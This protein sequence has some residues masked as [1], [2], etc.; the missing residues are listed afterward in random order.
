MMLVVLLGLFALG[1]GS[2]EADF[3]L[4]VRD[5]GEHYDRAELKARY[6][7]FKSNKAMVSAHNSQPD[8][9][10]TMVVNKFSA[11]TVSERSKYTGL[12]NE[13]NV[14]QTGT[15]QAPRG[16][17]VSPASH[18]NTA[19]GYVTRLKD[20]RSCG[21]CWAFA[22]SAAFEG[23]YA[24]A[25]G[26]LKSFSEKE[27]L[28]CTFE[29]SRD[30]CKG[31]WYDF[32][33]NYIRRNKRL[34][35]YQDAPYDFAKDRSCARY[36]AGVPNGIINAEFTQGHVKVGY[37]DRDLQNAAYKAVVAVAMIVDQSFFS[38]GSGNYNGC[39][40]YKSCGHAVTLTG[41]T[42]EYWTVK[43]SW[44]RNW[45]MSGY[46]R[47]SRQRSNI[48]RLA[49]YAKY[50]IVT[51]LDTA[52]PDT[53]DSTEPRRRKPNTGCAFGDKYPCSDMNCNYGCTSEGKC[54]S[55][56]NGFCGIQGS[57]RCSGCME[58]C[59]LGK[60]C[61]DHEDCSQYRY[62]SCDGSCTT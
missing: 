34:A 50:P 59:Y 38:Y 13:T 16:D 56:C 57:Q 7:L 43:N 23:A 30:G 48:C 51:A 58:W 25:T 4:F 47:F 9:Q 18:D 31:G 44:G 17:E 24:K 15:M 19:A 41:Y 26:V 32:A 45:G 39:K 21:S 11:M 10:Y 49:D 14:L 22:A 28:D 6:S 37:H 2:L 12:S 27:L 54:W 5:F 61:T 62:G 36:K 33:W 53:P 20:Q 55:Q 3:T 60:T 46:V 1:A 8:A 29:G 42:Q 40:T 52:H 35:S